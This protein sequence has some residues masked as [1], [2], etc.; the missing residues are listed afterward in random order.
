MFLETISMDS[1]VKACGA[2][3]SDLGGVRSFDETGYKKR[4][5]EIPDVLDYR[6][7]MMPIRD[8]GSRPTCA[9]Q[10]FSAIMEYQYTRTDGDF[11]YD[12]PMF[13][14]N[15]RENPGEGMSGKDLERIGGTYGI[16]SESTFPYIQSNYLTTPPTEA[17]TEAK[18]TRTKDMVVLNTIEDV[19][20]FLVFYGPCYMAFLVH[21]FGPQPWIR[22]GEDSFGGHAVC[23]VGYDK[24]GFLIRNSWGDSWADNGYSTF[25]YE[26]FGVQWEILGFI[27]EKPYGPFVEKKGCC[28]IQ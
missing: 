2:M 1:E 11:R 4:A 23:I 22:T 18:L 9:A 8:Q 12:S 28:S 21:N 10:T 7:Y 15:L 27:N 17:F 3:R 6:K 26:N 13:I 19:K 5:A 25:L 14:Y 24:K 20:K 16:C